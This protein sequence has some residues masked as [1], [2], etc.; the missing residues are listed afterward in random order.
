M[1]GRASIRLALVASTSFSSPWTGRPAVRLL[2]GCRARRS[3]L[4][5]LVDG[6]DCSDGVPRMSKR[7]NA[8]LPLCCLQAWL[9]SPSIVD[10]C[11]CYTQ[12]RA[13]KRLNLPLD[14]ARCAKRS[15]N[16]AETQHGVIVWKCGPPSEPFH[17][18]LQI[19][20]SRCSCG[21]SDYSYRQ[22]ATS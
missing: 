17:Q 15:R 11:V 18:V 5:P 9:P 14:M 3:R 7:Y 4:I 1:L 16:N 8:S 13:K 2:H 10:T 21:K 20:V 19:R 6:R 12:L 22:L